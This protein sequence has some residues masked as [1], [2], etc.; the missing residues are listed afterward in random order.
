VTARIL[1]GLTT[2]AM[3]VIVAQPTDVIKVRF[4]AQIKPDIQLNPYANQGT[5]M[6]Y[7]S[8]F[9]QEGMAGLWRGIYIFMLLFPFVFN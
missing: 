8:I 4:Q 2:G 6:A 1:A 3:A 7:K 5:W 9:T